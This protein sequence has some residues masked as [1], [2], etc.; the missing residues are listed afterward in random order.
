MKSGSFLDTLAKCSSAVRNS[1]QAALHWMHGLSAVLPFGLRNG[2]LYVTASTFLLIQ[3]YV[4]ETRRLTAREYAQD[5]SPVSGVA[6]V[7]GELISKSA[8]KHVESTGPVASKA[9]LQGLGTQWE[10]QLVSA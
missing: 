3:I 7:G 5:L 10:E 1:C 9:M 2:R 6:S 8:G 4:D